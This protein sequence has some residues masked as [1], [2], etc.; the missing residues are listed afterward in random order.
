MVYLEKH[1]IV[2]LLSKAIGDGCTP[3]NTALGS[4]PCP[5]TK[6]VCIHYRVNDSTS[7]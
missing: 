4:K 3:P 7:I 5:S 1:E 2:L 6:F